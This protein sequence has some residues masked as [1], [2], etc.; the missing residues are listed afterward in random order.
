MAAVAVAAAVATLV[1]LALNG[2]GLRQIVFGYSLGGAV[3]GVAFGG[4]GARPS[5]RPR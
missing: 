3:L 1:L 2:E 4:V 5:S